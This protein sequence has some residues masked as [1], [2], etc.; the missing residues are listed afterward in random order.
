M[1]SEALLVGSTGQE[2]YHEVVRHVV[3]HGER[4][5]PR[6]IPTLDAGHVTVVLEDPRRA[7]PLGTGRKLS[8]SIAALEALQLVGGIA[9]PQLMP[10]SFDP[11]READ[12]TFWG[13]YGRRIGYQLLD[14]VRK[15]RV[16]SGTRQ[17][18]I[19]LWDPVLDNRSDKR[20]YP[21]TVAL[22]FALRGDVLDLNVTM[23][24][25]DVWRGA[26]YDWGQFTALQLTVARL[27]GVGYGR[28]RHTAWSLHLYES[29]VAG[30]AQVWSPTVLAREQFQPEGI[31]EEGQVEPY[32]VMVRA[33]Q[34]LERGVIGLREQPDKMTPS[35]RWYADA[36]EW[37]RERTS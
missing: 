16:D 14:V 4:R 35:E 18:V 15:L 37:R 31:G 32:E 10:T 2:F 36:L 24:S 5:S 22:G 12:G 21:C 3:E 33:Q 17:A 19:T 11:Y 28:Y 26:A 13:A 9:T 30:A 27:L 6:G 29:D 20:D 8:R 25:N 1:A 23:R 7:L 34:L